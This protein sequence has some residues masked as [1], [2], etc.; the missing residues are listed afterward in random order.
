MGDFE[1]KEEDE[2]LL[3]EWNPETKEY[4]GWEIKKK[5]SYSVNTK[6]VNFWRKEDVNK[7]GYQF[8]QIE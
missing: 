6:D 3:R 7:Y 2:L 4:T 5:V 1:I 8:I